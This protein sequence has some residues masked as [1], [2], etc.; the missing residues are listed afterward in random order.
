MDDWPDLPILCDN[1]LLAASVEHFDKVLD[2]LEKHEGVDFNQG[3][4]ARLLT[5]HHAERLR[6]LDKPIVRLACDS[7][8]EIPHFINAVDTLRRA[9][10]PKRWVR[11]YVLI[12]F[13]SDVDEAW[14][15]C[16]LV[17]KYAKPRPQWYHALGAMEYGT[18][19]QHQMDIGW[20][21]NDMKRIMG[22][23]Y[24]HRGTMPDSARRFVEEW[25]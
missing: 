7:E 22:Y 11:T 23:W 4:D 15:R 16:A 2:R 6:R 13:N 8:R 25:R 21:D 1:N 24:K 9:G 20:T 17:N 19:T 3:L 12:G 10:I 18:V 5:D 14:K